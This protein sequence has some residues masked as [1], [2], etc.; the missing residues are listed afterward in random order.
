[1]KMRY[2]IAIGLLI[3]LCACGALGLAGGAA[4]ILGKANSYASA[5][6]EEKQAKIGLWLM[7]TGAGSTILAL[8]VRWVDHKL[9]GKR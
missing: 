7:L 2:A 6:I 4:E 1:M 5:A 8:L 3:G 9:K